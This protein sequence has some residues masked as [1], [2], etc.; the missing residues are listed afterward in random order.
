MPKGRC[1][2]E[3]RRGTVTVKGRRYWNRLLR[4]AVGPH[5]WRVL[6]IGE[7]KVCQDFLAWSIPIAQ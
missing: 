6:R 1:R 7:A 2:L 4:E 3:S 5:H